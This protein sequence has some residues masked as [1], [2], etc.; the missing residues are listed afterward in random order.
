ME[1]YEESMWLMAIF[2][3]AVSWWMIEVWNDEQ[4]RA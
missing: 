2:F 4:P 3:A 1:V